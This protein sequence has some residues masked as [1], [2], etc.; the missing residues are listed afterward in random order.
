[1]SV[2]FIRGTSSQVSYISRDNIKEIGNF[3]INPS[4]TASLAMHRVCGNQRDATHR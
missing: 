4:D 1:M 3:N 2:E